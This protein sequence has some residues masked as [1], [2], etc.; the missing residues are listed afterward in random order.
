MK[1]EGKAIIACI[2]VSLVPDIVKAIRMTNMNQYSTYEKV[3][4][5]RCHQPMWLGAQ[6][7]RVLDQLAGAIAVC[8]ECLVRQAI[9]EGRNPADLEIVSLIDPKRKSH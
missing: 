7:K 9:A 1:S 8:M 4:C 3:E 6:G 2:P 5:P